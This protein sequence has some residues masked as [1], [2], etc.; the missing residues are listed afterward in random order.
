MRALQK[1]LSQIFLVM[2]FNFKVVNILH[3]ED[4]FWKISINIIGLNLSRKE[5][6]PKFI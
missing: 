1:P 5:E 3:N 4:N 6:R 2:I